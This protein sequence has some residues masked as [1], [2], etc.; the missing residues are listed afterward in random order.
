MNFDKR[1]ACS[2]SE[3]RDLLEAVN[4]WEDFIEKRAKFSYG[5]FSHLSG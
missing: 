2:R 5:L 4:T 1:G 3:Q